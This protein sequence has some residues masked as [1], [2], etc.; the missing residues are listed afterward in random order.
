MNQV[1]LARGRGVAAAEAQG[2]P[3]MLATLPEQDTKRLAPSLTINS[4][5]CLAVYRS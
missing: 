5:D 2:A 1:L 4:L 3:L